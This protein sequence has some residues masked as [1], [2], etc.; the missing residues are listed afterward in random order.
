[1]GKRKDEF[2]STIPLPM[3]LIVIFRQNCSRTWF[4]PYRRGTRRN[5]DLA[6]LR[7]THTLERGHDDKKKKRKWKKNTMYA[8][9]TFVSS[10]FRGASLDGNCANNARYIIWTMDNF[11]ESRFRCSR[12]Q[13]FCDRF[14]HFPAPATSFCN[15]ARPL[16]V[17]SSP[18]FAR[19]VA[20]I[21]NRS[22]GFGGDSSRVTTLLLLF[23]WSNR[24]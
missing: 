2:F 20:S 8:R 11:P 16:P 18:P 7:T 21:A 13:C 6:N 14:E 22:T 4:L 23:N 1:M 17:R 15:M 24:A 10:V 19:P 9:V 5:G 12:H 3:R